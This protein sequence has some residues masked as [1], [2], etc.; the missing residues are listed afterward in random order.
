MCFIAHMANKVH[1]SGD[2]TIEIS[3]RIEIKDGTA[4]LDCEAQIQHALNKAGTEATAHCL[5]LFDADGSPITVGGI[6]M[7]SKGRV[8]K[9]YQTPYGEQMVERHVYQTPDGGKT[10]CPLDEKARIVNSSTPRFAKVAA[11][12]YSSMKSTTA[13]EDLEKNHGRKVSRCFLQD[14]SEDVAAILVQKEDHWHYD[15]P[16]LDGAVHTIGLG[17]DGTC[18]LFCD[19]GY[20][21]AMVGTIALYDAEGERLHTTYLGAEP[22]YGKEDFYRRMEK[23]I[24]QYKQRYPGVN[25]VGVADG[26]HDHWPWL[27]KFTDVQILDFFHA[28]GY[29]KGAAQGVCTSIKDRSA[30]I[31]DNAHNLK[32]KRGTAKNILNQMKEALENRRLGKAV[33]EELSRS[34]SYF[35]NY[36][37]QMKYASYRK[38]NLPIG[39]GI[40][41]AACKSLVKQRMC[42]SGMKWKSQGASV[43]LGLRGLTQTKGR[44]EQFWQKVSRF[45][46]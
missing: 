29:L 6:K 28:T 32:H 26:A 43:I 40:T 10:F 12:K 1:S 46:F 11:S 14:I 45:G 5:E 19:D 3:F 4:M 25:W 8:G 15:D 16:P 33:K 35:N 31:D 36:Q 42:G 34:I 38:Q 27:E 7:T 41:E 23:E 13:Q 30:W 39:S 37:G 2:K 22:Q 17:V 20:R 18:V 9:K 24:N 44:W 21:Q